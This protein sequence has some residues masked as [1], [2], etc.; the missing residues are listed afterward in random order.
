VALS[1][2]VKK[3]RKIKFLLPSKVERTL[4]VLDVLSSKRVLVEF[5]GRQLVVTDEE[6]HELM[7]GVFVSCGMIRESPPR[8]SR[9]AFEAP[10]EIRI[11]RV[12]G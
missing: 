4:V 6:R 9:L 1:I 8:E 11:E 12:A 10:R 5:G 7:P 2:G 3:G